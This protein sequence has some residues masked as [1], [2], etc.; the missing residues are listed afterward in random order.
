MKRLVRKAEYYSVVVRSP[1]GTHIIDT[2]QDSEEARQ[3]ALDFLGNYSTEVRPNS[4]V[5]QYGDTVYLKKTLNEPKKCKNKYCDDIAMDGKDY[6]MDC[7]ETGN[8]DEP[9][10]YQG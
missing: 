9:D 6:C 5:S 10:E 2:K 4:W 3:V 1:D 7:Y 8:T